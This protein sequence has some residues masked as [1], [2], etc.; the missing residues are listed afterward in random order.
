MTDA[1]PHDLPRLAA[2]SAV[3]GADPLLIQAAGGNTS[4]KADGLL[5]IKASGMRLA[6]AASR[7]VFVPVD[8]AAIRAALARGD[9]SADRTQDFVRGDWTLR[10]SIETSLHAVF[11][12]RVVIHV[13][14]VETIAVAVREDAETILRERLDGFGWAMVPYAKPGATLAALVAARLGPGV[15]VVVL[16][17]HGLIVAAETVA[18]AEALLARVVA[19]ISVGS[20]P[21]GA[22]DTAVLDAVARDGWVVPPDPALHGVALSPDRVRQARGGSLYPDHVIFCGIGVGVVEGGVIPDVPPP[23]P[24][25]VVPGAGVLMR[26]HASDAATALVRCLSDVLLRVPG[27]AVLTYLSDAQ[28]QE[29]IDWDAEAYRKTLNG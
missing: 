27:D 6:E 14:C 9:G 22:P 10:P 5:W 26:A 19:A 21:V 13:H 17:N 8:L 18:D 11:P 20:A 2:F 4:I 1:A 16:G 28:N 7:D 25:L 29:L 24:V 3:I 23:V 12:Q 15:D